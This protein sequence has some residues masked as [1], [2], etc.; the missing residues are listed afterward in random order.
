MFRAIVKAK[1]NQIS[2]LDAIV[3][4]LTNSCL[5]LGFHED[6]IKCYELIREHR[7]LFPF[8]GA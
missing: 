5:V 3:C 4:G 6:I 8:Q 2:S 7:F 1:G